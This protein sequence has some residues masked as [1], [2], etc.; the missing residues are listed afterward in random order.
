MYVEDTVGK[1]QVIQLPLIAGIVVFNSNF[2]VTL[3]R[4]FYPVKE[5]PVKE[6]VSSQRARR[7]ECGA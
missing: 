7:I 5:P 1:G 6:P 2:P 4:R 3:F